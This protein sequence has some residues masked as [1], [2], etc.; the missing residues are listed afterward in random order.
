MDKQPATE[1][2][3]L[4]HTCR[5]TT[6]VP[7]IVVVVFVVVQF[8]YGLSLHHRWL[9]AVVMVERVV[10]VS[11]CRKEWFNQHVESRLENCPS[12]PPKLSGPIPV[13]TVE[14][15][16]TAISRENSNVE[17]GGLWRP[18]DCMARHHVAIVVPYR[19][20]EWQL[21]VFVG[22]MHKFLEKQQLNYG[23]YIVEEALP[24]RFNRAMLMNIGY[25]EASKQANYSC[26]IFHDVDLLPEDDRNIYSCPDQPRHMSVA[27]DKFKYKY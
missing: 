16:W 19:D 14:R 7:V 2:S 6:R 5:W 27:V 4:S 26:Y 1:P 15:N 10:N 3:G 23:I 9:G 8:V 22:H 18:R 17:P 11:S 20:R 12:V 21:K 25:A 24:T 13:N